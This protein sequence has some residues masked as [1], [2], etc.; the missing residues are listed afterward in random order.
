MK[1]STAYISRY[2]SSLMRRWQQRSFRAQVEKD[3]LK[4]NLFEHRN[5]PTIW[6]HARMIFSQKK[7]FGNIISAVQMH[8]SGMKIAFS[9][10]GLFLV[11]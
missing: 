8:A 3:R 4:T 5:K 9:S 10:M 7:R 11:L 6:H 1:L 2:L